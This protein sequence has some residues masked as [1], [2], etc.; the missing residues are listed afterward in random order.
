MIKEGETPKEMAMQH[1]IAGAIVRVTE[2]EAEF[3]P[4]DSGAPSLKHPRGEPLSTPSYDKKVIKQMKKL[5]NR[6]ARDI[7]A[8]DQYFDVV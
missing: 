5:I 7:G 6:M 1:I 4:V 2:L 8:D 3:Y